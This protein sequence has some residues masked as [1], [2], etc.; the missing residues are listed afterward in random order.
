MVFGFPGSTDCY[1]SS[2]GVEQAVNLE[3]PKRVEIRKV[4]LDIMKKYMNENTT[5]RLKYASKH[6]QV[7]NYWKYFIGQSEQLK[8][9]KVAD[10]KRDRKS[11]RLNSSHVRISYA[12]FC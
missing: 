9:N 1:L 2:F 10:K 11:T 4:K 5:I 8:N 3:Q 7:A 6:A 12:V